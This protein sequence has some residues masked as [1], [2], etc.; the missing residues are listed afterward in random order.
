MPAGEEPH[1]RLRTAAASNAWV[2]LMAGFTTVQSVGSPQ[3]VPLR[4]AIARGLLPG[5]RILTA[6][7][8]LTGRGDETGTP[9]EIRAYVRKQKEVGRGPDQDLYAAGGILQGAM[10]FPRSN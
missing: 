4:D 7:E 9:D 5:P 3:D 8:A 6:V 1:R 2:T 10:T